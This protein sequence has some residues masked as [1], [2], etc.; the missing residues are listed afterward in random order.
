MTD[1]FAAV[2]NMSVTA[3][4]VIAA[5]C[6]ARLVLRKIR[7]PKWISYALWAVAGFRLAVPFTFESVMSLMPQ[8]IPEVSI[9]PRMYVDIPPASGTQE[10]TQWALSSDH[11]A[12]IK[13][14]WSAFDTLAVIWLIGIALMLLYSVFSYV[15]LLRRKDSVAT[16]FI[17]G[18]IKPKIHIPGGLSGDELRYALLHEQTHIKR[19]DYLV[20]L[21]AFA[22]LCVHWFNPLAWVAFVLLCADME[23]SCDERV[24]RELG[25][26]IKADYSQALLSLSVNRR[27]LNASP[28]AFGEGGI[29]E[30]VKNVLK[31]KKPSQVIIIVALALA[32]VLSVGFAVN[33]TVGTPLTDSESLENVPP[34]E[35][36]PPEPRTGPVSLGTYT[37]DDGMA[38]VILRDGGEFNIMW[39][40]ASYA[41]TGHF[42]MSGEMLT[43]TVTNGQE[44]VFRNRG[45]SIEFV[46]GVWQEYGIEPGTIFTLTERWEPE[47]QETMPTTPVAVGA[48]S[49]IRDKLYLGMSSEEVYALFGEPDF[50]EPGLLYGY[51]D[52]GAFDPG[53]SLPGVVQWISLK[54]GPDWAVV[55]LINAA[56]I[57][58]NN[59]KFN[60]PDGVYPTQSHVVLALDADQNGFTAYIMSLYLNYVRDEEYVV[61]ELG[62]THMPLALTFMKNSKGDY[63]LAEYWEP[64]DGTYYMPSIRSKFPE[65]VWDKVDT[66]LYIEANKK[67]CYEQAMYHFG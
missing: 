61:R 43:L 40:Q 45:G 14:V 35:L 36:M 21:L 59:G 38:G 67:S 47:P 22:L 7:A 66:Q 39:S 57:Q 54:D 52:I 60:E 46:K 13:P 30:R 51:T 64:G 62:G 1:I 32:V 18:F 27:I 49:D 37:T 10:W 11:S 58:H 53:L 41:P 34:E 63:E 29:K 26:G 50:H 2:L 55:D 4:F 20:K 44:F 28:L 17:F 19:R 23:M 33:R 3:A 31:F 15:R 16:P 42:S 25:V 6:I 65:S 9:P 24:L 56:V 5:L 48:A 8:G 12:Y